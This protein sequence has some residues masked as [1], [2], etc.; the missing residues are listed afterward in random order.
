[1]TIQVAQ[2]AKYAQK[3]ITEVQMILVVNH[4]HVQP[5]SEILPRDASFIRDV[6]NVHVSR[7]TKDNFVI[8]VQKVITIAQIQLM[9]FVWIANAIHMDQFRWNVIL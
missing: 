7:A 9:V 6:F 8:I 5:Q 4:A 1:M 2:T 3:D